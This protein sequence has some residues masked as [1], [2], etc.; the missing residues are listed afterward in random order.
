MWLRGKL[1]K[2][3]IRVKE[4][5]PNTY[6]NLVLLNKTYTLIEQRQ[7]MEVRTEFLNEEL[8]KHG[9][10]KC[11]YC[12][13]DDLIIKNGVGGT[14]ATVDHIKAV[15]MGGKQFDKNNFAVC[16]SSC[17]SKKGT[18]TLES[19]VNSGYLKTKRRLRKK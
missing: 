13:R 11:H 12:H 7:W 2:H 16:C 9:K 18:D 17:N 19:F 1:M 10:L 4:I 6:A 14:K 15:S 3:D 5:L 8:S